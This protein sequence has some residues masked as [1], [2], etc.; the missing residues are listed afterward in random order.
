VAG[1]IDDEG[2]H[3]NGGIGFEVMGF[4]EGGLDCCE[5]GL[6]RASGRWP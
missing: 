4:V 2:K 3:E 6:R 1:D 5:L